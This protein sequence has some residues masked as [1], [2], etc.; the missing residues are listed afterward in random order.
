MLRHTSS[1][2]PGAA[3]QCRLMTTAIA[4]SA[5]PGSPDP[6]ASQRDTTPTEFPVAKEDLPSLGRQDVAEPNSTLVSLHL[7]PLLGEPD[8]RAAC[9]GSPQR[10]DAGPAEPICHRQH[11]SSHQAGPSAGT[12]LSYRQPR[13]PLTPTISEQCK[14]FARA[15]GQRGHQRHT[16]PKDET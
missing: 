15:H 14:N 13:K 11:R 8:D 16:S 3:L 6:G 10:A 7:I 9:N 5:C 12:S 2:P 1:V 4:P